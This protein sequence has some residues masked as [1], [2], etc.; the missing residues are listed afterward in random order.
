M[1]GSTWTVLGVVF[2][3][4][5]LMVC[6]FGENVSYQEANESLTT[7]VNS[8]GDIGRDWVADFGRYAKG[9]ISP[10]ALLFSWVEDFVDWIVSLF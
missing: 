8:M 1:K 9:E 3:F 7:M 4:V 6:V 2:I 10:V 5:F